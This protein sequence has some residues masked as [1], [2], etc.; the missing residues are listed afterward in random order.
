MKITKE[1]YLKNPTGSSS[2]SYWKTN[3][4]VIPS[5]IRVI[6]D[7]QYVDN[8]IEIDEPYF[9]LVH[10][11]MDIKKPSLPDGFVLC[12][13]SLEEFVNH[14]NEC[15]EDISP[16]L[17]ELEEYQ[18][19][20]T[21]QKD[22]WFGIKEVK[23]NKLVASIIGEIDFS[24]KEGIIEWLQVSKD[25][26]RNGLASFLVHSFLEIVKSECD[27]VTVSGQMNNKTH[28][29]ELYL[30]C[31]FVNPVIWHILSK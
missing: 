7:D 17:H 19:R 11:L 6:R 25:Y 8:D 10:R 31:G 22:L 1:E 29:Y 18:N 20:P 2:L 23:T 16:S 26:R 14:I 3:S 15:Y 5:N 13:P 28:P 24:I 12:H 27:F 30:S 9:K 21:Y 4:F